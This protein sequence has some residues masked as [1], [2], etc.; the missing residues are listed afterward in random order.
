[1][2]SR[3]TKWA[4]NRHGNGP[5]SKALEIV[6]EQKSVVLRSHVPHDNVLRRHSG[7][8]ARRAWV[9]RS[10]TVD[11]FAVCGQADHHQWQADPKDDNSFSSLIYVAGT[12]LTL[13]PWDF[14]TKA[15]TSWS[16]TAKQEE[17]P[18][19]WDRYSKGLQRGCVTTSHKMPDGECSCQKDRNKHRLVRCSVI[20]RQLMHEL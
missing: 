7:R 17:L 14:G 1:M 10:S 13:V 19:R 11:M 2:S 16:R 15:C 12:A 20:P 3:S 9:G 4:W 8:D 5:T 18:V 6:G